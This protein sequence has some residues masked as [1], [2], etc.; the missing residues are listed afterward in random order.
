MFK[1]L[2]PW[3]NKKEVAHKNEDPFM[4]FHKELDT[5]FNHFL[6][7]FEAPGFAFPSLNR[8][9]K[10]WMKEPDMD[11]NENEKEIRITA[12]LPGI[13]EKDLDVSLE[14]NLLTVKGEKKEEKTSKQSRVHV[15]ERHYGSFVRRITVPFDRIDSGKIS[16]S[17]KKGVLTV[18]LPKIKD[19]QEKQKKIAIQTED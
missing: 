8:F 1:N 19:R 3:K 6:R 4:S 10:G 7:D 9:E 14:G 11:V 12:D 15:T 16:A 17:M 2:I 13:D 18:V 5:M